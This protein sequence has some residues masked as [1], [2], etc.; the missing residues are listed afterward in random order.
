MDTIFNGF[1]NALH[2]IGYHDPVHP[3]LTHMPIGLV[4]GALVFWFLAWF[5][6]HPSL[7]RAARYCLVLAWLFIFPAVFLGFMDWQHWYQGA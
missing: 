4:V 1:Y 2:A 6:T 3:T 5:L 7:A